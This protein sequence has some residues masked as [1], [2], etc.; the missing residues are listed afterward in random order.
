MIS[1]AP[2]RITP[3]AI[4]N[5]PSGAAPGSTVL[6]QLS[7]GRLLRVKFA[8]LDEWNQRVFTYE[9]PASEH[10]DFTA[11][12]ETNRDHFVNDWNMVED[13]EIDGTRGAVTV[14]VGTAG[15]TR[16]GAGHLVGGR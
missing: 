3:A 7:I 1:E 13:F 8:Q 6:V 2:S 12:V 14:R 11:G 9:V 15:P 4:T 5:D 16:A 10:G